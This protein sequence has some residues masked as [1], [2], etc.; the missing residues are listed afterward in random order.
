MTI[1]ERVIKV[2]SKN[3]ENQ[4]E[5]KPESR[6]VD[7]LEV[8]S[9]GRIMLLNAVEDEFNITIKDEDIDGLVTVN[10]I[11]EKLEKYGVA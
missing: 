8:D 11:I 4:T 9:F 3:M 10:D 5:V 7:D 6:L 2:I 1:K